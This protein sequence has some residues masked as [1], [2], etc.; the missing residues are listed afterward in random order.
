MSTTVQPKA[1]TAPS[2]PT[3]SA[4]PTAPTPADTEMRARVEQD[5]ARIMA[6]ITPRRW[7]FT[8]S[9]TGEPVSVTCMPECTIEHGADTETP[10]HPVDVYCWTGDD[11]VTLPIDTTG[12][13]EEYRVLGSRVEVHPFSP[14][15]A[16]RLPF[17]VIEV[18]DE[19]YI[20][21]LDPDAL[22]T[23]INVLAGRVSALRRTHA[24]LVRI[25]AE[26]QSRTGVQA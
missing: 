14:S 15:I 25:R 11:D 6:A 8:S 12:T 1:A 16:H 26:H 20:S 7:T 3:I 21:G 22:E 10:T 13:P 23:V 4:S 24:D 18:I 17:A 19:H 5:A 2:A 9:V